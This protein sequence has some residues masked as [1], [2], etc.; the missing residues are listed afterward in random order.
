MLIKECWPQTTSPLVTVLPTS[1]VV[2]YF[3]EEYDRQRSRVLP[4][5]L[6][7]ISFQ[8]SSRHFS[9]QKIHK[10]VLARLGPPKHGCTCILCTMHI[11][12]AMLHAY[13][14]HLPKAIYL[15]R[16][17]I[18]ST[19]LGF[20]YFFGYANAFPPLFRAGS[21]CIPGN[22]NFAYPQNA[23]PLP[24]KFHYRSMIWMSTSH[25]LPT[26]IFIGLAFMI[27]LLVK[28]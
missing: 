15:W 4:L 21:R 16:Q 26:T 17:K 9:P 3:R 27:S 22:R 12:I 8:F 2:H 23:Y 5:F 24:A 28:N 6:P 25:R 19:Q 18:L 13:L 20:E 7:P 11:I 10:V 1:R 14:I